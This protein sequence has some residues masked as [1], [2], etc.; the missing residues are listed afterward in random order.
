VDRHNQPGRIFALLVLLPLAASSGLPG[1]S[2]F[3]AFYRPGVL[4]L[5][6]ATLSSLCCRRRLS[7]PAGLATTP[8]W[9]A[10]EWPR[11]A[12][13]SLHIRGKSWP[14]YGTCA[15]WP[16]RCSH[17]TLGGFSPGFPVAGRACL[18]GR[19]SPVSARTGGHARS[20]CSCCRHPGPALYSP[21]WTSAIIRPF[22]FGVAAVGFL[23]VNVWKAPLGS[24]SSQGA[25]Q[26]WRS[27]F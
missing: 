9:S 16:C 4:V 13:P 5:A 25:S 10:M 27:R 22:D 11:R 18:L 19:F 23:L 6:V 15:E 24:L 12:R 21:V 26:G 2:L 1:I 20:E 8:S 7:I 3:D 14:R 17:R